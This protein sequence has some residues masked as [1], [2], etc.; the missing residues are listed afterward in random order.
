MQ[1]TDKQIAEVQNQFA[2]MLNDLTSADDE[3]MA[4]LNDYIRMIEG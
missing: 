3:I 4:S 2:S 1:D